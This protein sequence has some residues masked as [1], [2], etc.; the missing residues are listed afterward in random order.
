ML[1]AQFPI[2]LVDDDEQIADVLKRAAQSSFPEAS[3]I[4]VASFEEAKSYIDDLE[5]R[6]PKIVLLDIDL[7]GAVDGLDFLAMLRAHP[8]GR[9]LPVVMLSGSKTPRQIERSYAFGASAFTVKPYSYSDWKTYLYNL[10]TYWFETVTLLDFR[11]RR[12]A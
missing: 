10:R 2:L 3:F 7:K 11:H 4:H 5:G 6:G 8:K 9:L 12:E 1:Q